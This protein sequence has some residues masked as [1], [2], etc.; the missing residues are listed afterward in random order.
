MPFQKG[1]KLGGK[2]KKVYQKYN[3]KESKVIPETTELL[4]EPIEGENS[5]SSTINYMTKFVNVTK[6]INEKE[7]SIKKLCGWEPVEPMK[8]AG[9]SILCR[10]KYLTY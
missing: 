9:N 8:R 10:R 1:N 6:F 5:V 4:S 3:K 7:L 2:K